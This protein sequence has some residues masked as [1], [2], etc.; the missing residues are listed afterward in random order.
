MPPIQKQVRPALVTPGKAQ[1]ELIPHRNVQILVA[2]MPDVRPLASILRSLSFRAV[3]PA[4]FD[5]ACSAGGK[6][7]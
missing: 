4:R 6:L 2:N 5:R 3:S 7:D 1:R